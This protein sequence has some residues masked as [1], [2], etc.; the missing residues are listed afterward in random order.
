MTNG[1]KFLIK[2]HFQRRYSQDDID[3][4]N[5]RSIIVK[6]LSSKFNSS[7]VEVFAIIKSLQ[8]KHDW[9]PF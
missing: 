3:G 2:N 1:D 8:T 7:R 6:V 9:V 5:V 4:L